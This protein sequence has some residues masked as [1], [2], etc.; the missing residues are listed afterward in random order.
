MDEVLP[1]S[2]RVALDCFAW[3]GS[4]LVAALD[5]GAGKVISIEKEGRYVKIAKRRVECA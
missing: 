2:G 4:S 5:A 1:A 3:S